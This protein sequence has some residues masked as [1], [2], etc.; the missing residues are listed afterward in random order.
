MPTMI[1]YALRETNPD[2]YPLPVTPGISPLR[3]LAIGLAL[4]LSAWL[5]AGW[6]LWVVTA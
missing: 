1:E 5:A 2:T 6:L 3:G 4:G